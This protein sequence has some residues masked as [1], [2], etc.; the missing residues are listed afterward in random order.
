MRRALFTVL[1]FLLGSQACSAQRGQR[2]PKDKGHD[3]DLSVWRAKFRPAVAADAVPVDTVSEAHPNGEFRF[4]VNDRLHP[5]LDS[6]SRLQLSRKFIDG[7]SIQL[8]SGTKRELAMEAKKV[9]ATKHPD[10]T[11]DLLYQQPNFRVKVGRYF[12][13]LEAYRDFAA[14]RKSFPAAIIIPEKILVR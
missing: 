9:L 14:L 6:I 1:I 10:L 2:E 4:S 12:T 13:R 8:Y 7:F 11:G 5:I 3:E